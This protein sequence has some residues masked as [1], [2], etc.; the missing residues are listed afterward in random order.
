MS[1]QSQ[2]EIATRT[3][4][5]AMLTEKARAGQTSA[6]IALERALRNRSALRN[7][8]LDDD[9]DELERLMEY[10]PEAD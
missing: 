8:P 4:V 3:E 5:L 6:M 1:D 7:E 2:P 10:G 9:F